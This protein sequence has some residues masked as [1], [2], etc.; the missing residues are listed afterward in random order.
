M[1]LDKALYWMAV[2]VMA[3]AAGNSLIH[4]N[5]DFARRVEA[6]YEAAVQCVS[7]EASGYLAYAQAALRGDHPAT[8]CKRTAPEVK[9][10]SVR[11]ELACRQAALARQQMA[12]VKMRSMDVERIQRQVNSAVRVSLRGP[13]EIRIEVPE[14]P[15]ISIGDSM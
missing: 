13:Q 12:L 8:R 14:A 3:F 7:T 6:R 1:Q 9:L 11:A 2:G 5:N 15:V 4:R 10:A